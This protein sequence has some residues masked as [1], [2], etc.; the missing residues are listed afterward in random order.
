MVC[1]R[2]MCAVHRS[3]EMRPLPEPLAEIKVLRCFS[4]KI[5]KHSRYAAYMLGGA[6]WWITIIIIEVDVCH[7]NGTICRAISA[8]RQCFFC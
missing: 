3:R 7:S 1:S 2:G 5:Y 8:M 4:I 6:E